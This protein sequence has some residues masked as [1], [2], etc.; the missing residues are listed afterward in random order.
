MEF[1]PNV[2]V[3]QEG[4]RLKIRPEVFD[5]TS[6]RLNCQLDLCKIRS[7]ETLAIPGVGGHG[8][9]NVQMP[10]VASTQFR[11]CLDMPIN[12]TLAVSAFETDAAGS[13]HSVVILC[14]CSMRDIEAATAV[15]R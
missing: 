3:Y 5:G 12:Y 15:H 1:A 2:K 11:T 13:K 9:F 7:V 6:V 14:Q 4:T 8:D 10:E